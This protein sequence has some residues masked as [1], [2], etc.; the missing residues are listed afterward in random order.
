MKKLLYVPVLLM[1]VLSLSACQLHTGLGGLIGGSKSTTNA[2]KVK[3]THTAPAPVASG[4]V[5]VV[6]NTS[7][8]QPSTLE[9]KV[10]T[11]VT[12]TNSDSV[13]HTITSDTSGIFDSGPM[14]NGATFMFTFTRPGT[15]AYHSSSDPTL[16]GAIIVTQ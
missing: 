6:I 8:Y 2:K 5:K 15:Y 16:K 7:G 4:N 3:A 11:V 10:G 1:L 14:E 12:W 9:V 13:A